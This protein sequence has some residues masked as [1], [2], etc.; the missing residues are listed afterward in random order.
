V[1]VTFYEDDGEKESSPGRV[2]SGHKVRGS[3][4]GGGAVVEPLGGRAYSLW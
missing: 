2:I 1:Q 3:P 4:W